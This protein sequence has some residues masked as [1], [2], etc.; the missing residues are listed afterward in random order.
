[1]LT[2]FSNGFLMLLYR[3]LEAVIVPAYE[4]HLKII[5]ELEEEDAD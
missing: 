4:K 1:M 5:L 3:L 2:K